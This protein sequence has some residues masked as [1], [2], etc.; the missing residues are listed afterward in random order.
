MAAW[1]HVGPF[2]FSGSLPGRKSILFQPRYNKCCT[3]LQLNKRPC[4]ILFCKYLRI[5]FSFGA[6]FDLESF[7]WVNTGKLGI[8]LTGMGEAFFL[9][10]IS[11]IFSVHYEDT[12]CEYDFRFLSTWRS[13][14][15]T[16]SL[17]MS[18]IFSAQ[19]VACC[20]GSSWN[21]WHLQLPTYP[22][23]NKIL[24]SAGSSL[25]FTAYF[26]ENFYKLFTKFSNFI[27]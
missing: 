8:I 11:E 26:S 9:H 6:K 20:K 19:F 1:K 23:S 12:I 25:E 14:I 24:S 3:L 5:N 2:L 10:S 13:F 27:C 15:E 4:H 21:P 16:R 17:M 7:S 18:L 22:F